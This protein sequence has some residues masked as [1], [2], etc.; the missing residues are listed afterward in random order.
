MNYQKHYDTLIARGQRTLIHGYRENHHIIPKCMGGSN[1]KENLVYLTAEEHYV[2][3]QLLIKIYPQEYKLKLAMKRMC[4]SNGIQLRNNKMFG[5]IR[6]EIAL[7]ISLSNTGRKLGPRPQEVKD[8]ISA[9]NTGKIRTEAMRKVTSECRIGKKNSIE[10][11]EKISLSLI[12]NQRGFKKGVPPL[13][14][15][16]PN[17]VEKRNKISQSLKNK[18]WS[19]ARRDA[20]NNRSK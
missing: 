19:Q 16:V 12:G 17:S 20:Q 6:K 18:P 3:H 5:W 10:Q 4:V 8:K 14:K 11:N 1:N 15:D 13:N 9:G 2:A 7:G